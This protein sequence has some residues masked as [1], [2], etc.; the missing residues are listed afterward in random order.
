MNPA[1]DCMVPWAY[2]EALATVKSPPAPKAGKAPPGGNS[3][4]TDLGAARRA[5]LAAA[6]AAS[7]GK[8]NAKD[9]EVNPLREEIQRIFS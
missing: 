4:K 9:A 3:S 6:K 5:E 8:T 2:K 1:L 7:S